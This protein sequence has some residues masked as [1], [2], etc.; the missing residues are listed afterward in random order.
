MP[1]S[2]YFTVSCP[3]CRT[4]FPVD[5][6][7]VPEGGV[8]AV[9]SECLRVFRVAVP[10][11]L[12]EE[13][14]ASGPDEW[15]G[16]E[17]VGGVLIEPEAP[18]S[19]LDDGP[20]VAESVEGTEEAVL[21]TETGVDPTAE[22]QDA[23]ELDDPFPEPEGVTVQDALPEADEVSVE[24]EWLEEEVV[25]E[26]DLREPDE[27]VIEDALIDPEAV[28][29]EEEVLEP[30]DVAV[31]E[32]H[33]EPETKPAEAA[34]PPAPSE[35]AEPPSGVAGKTLSEG[36][37]RFG[38]RDPAERARR[39]ARVLVSDMITY[40][41]ARYE[42]ALENDTVKERFAE[43]VEKSWKEFVEQVGDEIA[44]SSPYFVEALN[45]ILARGRTLYRG[46]GRPE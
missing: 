11:G 18:G 14:P 23:Q 31:E 4:E 1:A 37:A 10:D 5:P 9:C 29:V 38:R 40:H 24:E 32:A 42:E 28:A 39:L 25:F 34:A 13:F 26:D 2:V 12:L 7:R 27:M 43:E 45:E 17:T 33:V 6:D 41:P 8:P 21:E 3:S 19:A 46:V 22:V 35:P 44:E 15:T 36:A 30:G 20:V 16:E